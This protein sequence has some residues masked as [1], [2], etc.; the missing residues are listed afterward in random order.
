MLV[1]TGMTQMA[2]ECRALPSARMIFERPVLVMAPIVRWLGVSRED[3][4]K[5]ERKRGPEG[6][7]ILP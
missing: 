3:V 2:V 1:V 4:V 7:K 6:E 5:P